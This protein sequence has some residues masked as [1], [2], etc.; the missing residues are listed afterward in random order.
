MPTLHLQHNLHK[1][2]LQ[3]KKERTKREKRET[4]SNSFIILLFFCSEPFDP[5]GSHIHDQKS[6]I[7]AQII[8]LINVK[9]NTVNH[10][11]GYA[12]SFT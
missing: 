7:D 3:P 2:K 8:D 1:K 5:S 6:C 9:R 4:R 10:R 11:H 12:R